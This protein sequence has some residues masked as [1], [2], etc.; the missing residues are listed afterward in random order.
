MRAGELQRITERSG[1]TEAV[2]E[3]EHERHDP[4]ALRPG[5]QHVLHGHVYD[6]RRD[7]YFHE[8]SEPRG[9]RHDPERRSDERD[10]MG[11]RE[12]GDHAH[13]RTP[14]TEGQH[15]AQ[16][17]EQMIESAQHVFDTVTDEQRR[18]VP[19]ARIHPHR[20][21]VPLEAV[22]ALGAVGVH[23]RQETGGADTQIGPARFDHEV[24]GQRGGG[25]L[26]QHFEAQLPVRQVS[27]RG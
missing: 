21:G 17:E 16:H 22:A 7:E 14:L 18:G 25:D 19:P 4:P 20:A 13:Q 26:Q 5:P 15:E 2:H 6:R 3:A 12:G 8:R 27:G 10:G 9:R 24:S 11:H 1:K 23:Q